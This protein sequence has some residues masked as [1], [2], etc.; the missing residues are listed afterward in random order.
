MGSPLGPVL[1]NVF[2]GYCESR[3]D[4]IKWPQLYVRFVDD[5]FTHFESRCDSEA[6]LDE[7]NDVHPALRFTCEHEDCN[8][9][10]FLVLVEKTCEGVVTS[11]YRKLSFLDV[12]VEKTCEGVVTSVYRKPTFTGQYIM[13]DSYCSSQYKT[14]LVRNLADRARRIC[15]ESKSQAELDFLRSVF[16]KNGYPSSLLVKL[17]TNNAP[18][19]EL[20]IGLAP[21]RVFLCL[22]WK[23]AEST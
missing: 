10:S 21:C 3:M 5:S 8:K 11:V 18:H 22:S 9:L 6:F 1:A 16:L 20:T 12:L 7:L 17:L 2:V 19:K 4:K 23:G 13:Y 15:S 14:N